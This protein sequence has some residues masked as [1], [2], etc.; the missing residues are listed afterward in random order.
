MRKKTQKM[1]ALR[2]SPRKTF[3]LNRVAISLNLIKN[4]FKSKSQVV[5]LR[6]LKRRVLIVSPKKLNKNNLKNPN[7]PLRNQSKTMNLVMMRKKKLSQN[8]NLRKM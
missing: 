3:N 2:Q 4:Q 1:K 6:T 7:H 8:S 5:T